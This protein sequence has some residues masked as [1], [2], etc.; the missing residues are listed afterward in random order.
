MYA[1]WSV[2]F[3]PA[4]RS[5][6]VYLFL[7]TYYFSLS[8]YQIYSAIYNVNSDVRLD[9]IYLTD[10]KALDIHHYHRRT[11][12][13][14]GMVEQLISR[15]VLIA[16]GMCVFFFFFWISKEHGLCGLQ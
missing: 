4:L 2:F 8:A 13:E 10:V 14:S 12:A 6:S 3:S 16:L 5:S 11:G 7:Y 9:Y 1:L 15:C